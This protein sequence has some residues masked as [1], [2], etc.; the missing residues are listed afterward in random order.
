MAGN[1]SRFP[2]EQFKKPKPLIEVNSA[3]MITRA[4]E[5]LDIDGKYHI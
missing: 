3:P 4:V 2:L 5:S 1:G